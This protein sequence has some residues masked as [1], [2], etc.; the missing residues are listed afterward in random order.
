MLDSLWF[1]SFVNSTKVVHKF[2]FLLISLRSQ[3]TPS[4]ADIVGSSLSQLYFTL[5]SP[6]WERLNSSTHSTTAVMRALE[7]RLSPV[8]SWLGSTACNR[9]IRRFV[10]TS[11]CGVDNPSPR[12]YV[13]YFF[14]YSLFCRYK[15]S[16]IYQTTEKYENIAQ[17]FHPAIKNRQFFSGFR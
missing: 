5:N 1:R 17:L 4:C 13:H 8:S 10:L 3:F 2:R 14:G 12:Q 6:L 7:L 15:R 16:L 9:A 11:Q